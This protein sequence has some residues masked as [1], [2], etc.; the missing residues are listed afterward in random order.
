MK[1]IK[2]LFAFMG[3]FAMLFYACSKDDNSAPSSDE[4]ATLSF[5]AIVQ[6]LADKSGDKQFDIGDIPAC[7]EDAPN[8]V[9]IILMQGDTE[10][11]GAEGEPFRIDLVAGQVFTEE[12]PELEL[13]PGTYSLEHFA[14]YNTAGELIWLAPKGG[15][16]ADFVDNALPL[17]ISLGAGVKK[18][19]DVSVLCYDDRDVNQYGYLFFELDATKAVEFCFF[20]NYCPPGEDG[21]HYTANYSVNI[22]WGTDD[23]GTP[24]YTDV[25]PTTGIN[26][27]GDYFAEPTCFILPDN[28]DLNEPYLYY[29][30]TLLDWPD[31]YGSVAAGTMIS[32]TLTAQ[33]IMDNFDGD[34]NV[35][36]EHLKFN[37]DGETP[38]PVDDD[39]DGVPNDDDNCPNDHNP[40]QANSDDDSYGDVCDNCPDDTNEDQ[41]DGD[42]DGYGDVCDNCP[43]IYNP[44]QLDSDNDGMGNA[45]DP[46]PGEDDDRDELE[47]CETAIMFGDTEWI[48][49]GLTDV[50]WGWTEEYTNEGDK[51]YQI[52]AGAGQNNLE[53]GY[54]VGQVILDVEGSNYT[55]EIVPFTGNQFDDIHVYIDDMEQESIAPG[56][57]DN[58]EGDGLT[59]EFSDE[60]GMFWFTVH[61][62]NACPAE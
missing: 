27:A 42:E 61:I 30:V 5:A 19:V 16:L 39:D 6:D 26:D 9:E 28:D 31:N 59:Y 56:Q 36:Y 4:K 38:P 45:C 35:D 11:V 43:D 14:V 10:V 25:M 32:G 18:Y 24:L 1:K 52:W 46:T 22:W 34:D 41:A 51:V 49:L 54:Y 37:C 44:Y 23:T 55:L 47:G 50:R 60:D 29:E 53:K 58:T 8:Y 21:R 7:S 20:A 3:V 48:E 33:D 15:V 62:G 12:I 40:D 17:N 13:D 2:F 57:F